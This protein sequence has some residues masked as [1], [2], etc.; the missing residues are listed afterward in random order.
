MSNFTPPHGQNVVN[1]NILTPPHTGRQ[2]LCVLVALFFACGIVFL[3]YR[4]G[5]SPKPVVL[6]RAFLDNIDSINHYAD[7]S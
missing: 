2:V 4:R 5:S 6:D 7:F 1:D 3:G